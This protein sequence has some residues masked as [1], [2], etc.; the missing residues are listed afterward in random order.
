MFI[1]L[2]DMFTVGEPIDYVTLL[3]RLRMEKAFDEATIK[4]Y[5]INLCESA[6]SVSNAELYAGFVRNK[7]EI[8]KLISAARDIIE[9][10]SSGHGET[11]EI[12]DAAE[13]KIYD[14]RKGKDIQGLRD[15]KSVIIEKTF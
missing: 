9:E 5:L 1:L 6:P 3:N 7:Y 14:I 10:A 15:I 2:M 4:P 12:I 11:S 8:R 13:Q